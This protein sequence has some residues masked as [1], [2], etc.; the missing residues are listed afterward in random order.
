[1]GVDKVNKYISSKTNIFFMIS[2]PFIIWSSYAHPVNNNDYYFES[3]LIKGNAL[4]NSALDKF[5][6]SKNEIQ[7]GNYNVEIY[8]NNVFRGISTVSFLEN[9][10]KEIRACLSLEQI[11]MLGL[12]KEITQIN[13]NC[14]FSD[15]IEDNINYK[16]DFQ[17]LRLNF[18]IPQSQLINL[19]SSF[20]QEDSLDSGESM[21]FTNYNINQYHVDYNNGASNIDSTYLNLTSGFNLGLWSYR[22]NSNYSHTSKIGG[23][24][25]TTRRYIQRGIYSIKSELLIGEGFTSGS[26]LPG[27]GFKGIQLRSD[28]R[29]LPNSARGYAPRIQGI[30][31]SNA[32]VIVWQ[33][34]NKI[35]E[36]T[37]A[38][39]PFVID[40]LNSTNYAGDL[41]VEVVEA[42]GSINSFTVPFSAVPE[43]VRPGDTKYAVTV[44]ESRYVGNNDKFSEFIIQHGL[45][46]SITIN[47]ANQLASGYQG[48]TVGSV[49]TNQLGAF[50]VNT[51]FSNA[52]LPNNN[53]ETGW[54]F[55]ISYS[56]TFQPTNTSVALS[57]Y[58]Y[59]TNGFRSLSDTL[60]ANRYADNGD[61]DWKN[62][63]MRQ[64][65]RFDITINQ[66]LNEYGNL[67]LSASR[68]DYH[69][70]NA[71]NK[72]L[73]LTWS[74]VFSNGISLNLSIARMTN[75]LANDLIYSGGEKGSD[76]KQTFTSLGLTIPLGSSKYSPDMTFSTTHTKGQS[77]YQTTVNGII[78]TESQYINYGISY[79]ADNQI[80]DGT[81][82]GTLQ[83]QFPYANVQG[84]ISRN[85]DYFQASGNAQG[86]VV[87]HKGGVTF[88]PYLSDTFAIIEAKGATGATVNNYNTKIDSFGYAIV[89][90]LIPYQY[91]S[92]MLSSDGIDSKAEIKQP[93]KKVAPY[94]GIGIKL[95]Y[96]IETGTPVLLT[97]LNKLK[98]G[99]PMGS[100]AFDKKGKLI[101][102][103][104]QANQL[105]FRANSASGDI[106]VKWG[107]SDNEQ[108]EV[109]YK[110]PAHSD[111]PLISSVSI[112]E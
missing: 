28:D 55:H 17:Q 62:K 30:A 26:I 57:S 71:T 31:N 65:S 27:I 91:N 69:N 23:K 40:D 95:K 107:E 35:Y 24:W 81:L 22:Q 105:Y 96:D 104:G 3:S 42:N 89:P 41:R 63:I 8:V 102:M 60:E 93:E 75:A 11:A 68:E 9:K 111:T 64:R 45:S 52:K 10:N 25:D 20:I 80:S 106:I 67:G 99:I 86:S 98:D 87:V 13:G 12:K 43:S 1:M 85:N 73:Q 58:H 82:S 48:V 29:M 33:G 36:T 88:G 110:L 7:A 100:Q 61:N 39:G 84:T 14:L 90:S 38:P 78:P 47:L 112:C 59:S 109:N 72:Q 74:K 16:F 66:D 103:V 77:N 79:N 34:E 53:K 97:L 54:K 51:T 101:G 50:S 56:K 19:K 21:L 83:T 6:Y 49:Y 5:N 70:S 76:K 46:N 94:S 4:S 15:E 108:C 44:G 2:L 37:V 32:K 18:V 92:V